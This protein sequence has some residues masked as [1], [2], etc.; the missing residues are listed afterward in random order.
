MSDIETILATTPKMYGHFIYLIEIIECSE[1]FI[2]TPKKIELQS[3]TW[4]EYKHHNTLKFLVCIAPNSGIIF[5]Q[6]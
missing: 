2:E 3:A 5:C 1:I 6:E 4:S